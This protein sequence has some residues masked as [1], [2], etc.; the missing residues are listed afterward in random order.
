MDGM[1][2]LALDIG[3]KQIGVA[4]SDPLGLICRPIGTIT[5][6][7][8]RNDLD[9]L[10]QTIAENEAEILVVGFPRNMDGTFGPQAARI[11]RMIGS[12]QNL[13]LP[14]YKVDERLSSREAEQRMIDAGLDARER[15]LKRD[16]FSAAVILQRYLD[17][18]PL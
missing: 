18:G 7:S 6:T 13:G 5:R 15:N 12:L 14:V 11:D 8:L 4:V 9:T 10:R 16:A 3:E 1:K 17:E 2:A